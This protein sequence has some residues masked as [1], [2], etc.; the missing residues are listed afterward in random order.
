MSVILDIW[1]FADYTS[2]VQRSCKF[3]YLEGQVELNHFK[4]L[5]I[6][7]RQQLRGNFIKLTS[8]L[9]SSRSKL[10]NELSIKYYHS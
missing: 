2:R 6:F 4:Q 7:P 5:L 10:I 9:K 1:D 3:C 8:L